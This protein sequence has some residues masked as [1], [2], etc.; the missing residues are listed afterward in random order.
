MLT[1]ELLERKNTNLITTPADTGIKEAMGILLANKIS[2][3]PV[4]TTGNKLIGIIS[5]K[6][7]FSAIYSDHQVMN[8]GTVGDLMTEDVIV[9]VAEDSADYIASLMTQN[10]IRHIPILEK[11]RIIGLLSIGDMV[12]AQISHMEVENRYLKNYIEGS[13]PG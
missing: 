12:K 13:Y 10:K 1:R 5:D 4:V 3:L 2:C 6:D 7:I 9:G 8:S 11:N